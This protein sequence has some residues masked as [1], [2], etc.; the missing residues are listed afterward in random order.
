LVLYK[1]LSQANWGIFGERGIYGKLGF[2][3]FG[4]VLSY[5]INWNR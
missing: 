4:E 2:R 1:Y 3:D 5:S